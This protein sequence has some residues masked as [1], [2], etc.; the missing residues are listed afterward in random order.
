MKMELKDVKMVKLK[1]TLYTYSK[2]CNLHS[3]TY[4]RY[5]DKKCPHM[6][7][8][9]KQLPTT[10]ELSRFPWGPLRAD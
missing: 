8:G 10:C 1:Y 3:Q 2:R 4:L 5:W 6:D 9:E 7:D